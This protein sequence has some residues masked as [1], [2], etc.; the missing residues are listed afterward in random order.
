[1]HRF[2]QIVLMVFC[3]SAGAPALAVLPDE[4][5]DDPALEAR[6]RAISREL[7][8]VVC[9]NESIDASNAPLARDLRLLIRARLA[10]GDDDEAVTAFVVARYGRFVLLRPPLGA[11]TLALWLGPFLV[12]LAALVGGVVFLRRPRAAEPPAP[13]TADERHRLDALIGNDK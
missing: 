2:F 13:L 8:C 12:L 7:R 11:D 10:Q 3:F 6:A 4:V 9:Q 5:M 1:M